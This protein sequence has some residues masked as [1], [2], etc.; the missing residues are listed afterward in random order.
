MSPILSGNLRHGKGPSILGENERASLTL[1]LKWMKPD[2]EKS[3]I[4]KNIYLLFI[5]LVI[6]S[7]I[8]FC[9]RIRGAYKN[10]SLER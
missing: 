8:A 9:L 3:R 4:S 1:G 5:L 7:Q 2:S 10:T 6:H